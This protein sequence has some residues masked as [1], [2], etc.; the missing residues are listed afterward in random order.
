VSKK[1]IYIELLLT[2]IHTR[3]RV[4]CDV[5]IKVQNITEEYDDKVAICLVQYNFVANSTKKDS[6]TN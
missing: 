4:I 2:Y 1:V 3:V 5:T 6:N